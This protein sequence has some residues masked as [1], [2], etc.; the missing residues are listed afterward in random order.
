METKQHKIR[1]V[2]GDIKRTS[3]LIDPNIPVGIIDADGNE[4]QNTNIIDEGASTS[5]LMKKHYG[6]R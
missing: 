3:V 4:V 1:V 2:L 6:K 5:A